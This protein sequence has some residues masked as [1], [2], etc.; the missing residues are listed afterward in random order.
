MKETVE[1]REP[2]DLRAHFHKRQRECHVEKSSYETWLGL[3]TPVRWVTIIGG[4]VL[5]AVAGGVVL[6]AEYWPPGESWRVYG[7]GCAIV[8]SVLT[9]IHTSL[10]CDAH[11]TE[12]R[13]LIQLYSGLEGAY[14]AA[15]LVTR[16]RLRMRFDELEAKFQE[17]RSEATASPPQWC[18]RHAKSDVDA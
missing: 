13:R 8:A 17:A 2:T 18:R 3:L 12:C 7:A 1:E 16:D 14:E 4:I 9:G 5:S 11:Q 10:N 15:P 6:L